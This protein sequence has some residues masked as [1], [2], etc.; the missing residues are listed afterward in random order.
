L[1]ALVFTGAMLLC[2]EMSEECWPVSPHKHIWFTRSSLW[3][4]SQH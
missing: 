4:C 2:G 1:K 3:C